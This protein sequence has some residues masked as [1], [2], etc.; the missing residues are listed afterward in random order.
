MP[1]AFL[2]RGGDHDAI[3][4]LLL[5]PRITQK[6]EILISQVREKYKSIEKIDRYIKFS[7]IK[8]YFVNISYNI[9]FLLFI[10]TEL[11]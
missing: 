8:F 7:L 10:T 1:P 2:A 6:T 3:L 5:I 4:M 9:F 11:P